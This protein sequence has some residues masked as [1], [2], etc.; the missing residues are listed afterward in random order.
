MKRRR[1]FL[2]AARGRRAVRPNL[3][4]QGRRRTADPDAVIRVGF[5]AS[6]K[7]G[8]AVLRNRARRRMRVAA[9]AVLAEQGRP[10]WDY[11]LIARRGATA[12]AVFGRLL[13]DLDAA[14]REVHRPRRVRSREE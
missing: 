2:A 11:V 1:S 13:A 5:T 10:G 9:R 6:R 8:N 4:L 12:R 3:I 7:T 14:V